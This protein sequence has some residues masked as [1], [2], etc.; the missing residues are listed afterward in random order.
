MPSA[1]LDHLSGARCIASFWIAC[2]HFLPSA[3]EWDTVS[4]ILLRSGVAVEFFITLSGFVTHWAYAEKAH[5]GTRGG[6]LQLYVRRF[7]R[8]AFTA[9]A[10]TFYMIGVNRAAGIVSTSP[11][12]FHAS[13]LCFVQPWLLPVL[14]S[15]A[16]FCP[17]GVVWTVACLLPSWLLYPFVHHRHLTAISFTRLLPLLLLALW[18]ALM[19]LIVTIWTAQGFYLSPSEATL[20][21]MW[22][23]ACLPAFAI[24]A[25]AAEA[26]RRHVRRRLPSRPDSHGTDESRPLTADAQSTTREATTTNHPLPVRGTS[27]YTRG[28]LADVAIIGP[29][30]IVC[31]LPAFH[32]DASG[33][34]A[35]PDVNSRDGYEPLLL[36]AF[37]PCF[38]AFLYATSTADTASG[39]RPGVIERL[40]RHPALV[41]LGDFSFVVF[42]FQAPVFRTF[43]IVYG[44]RRFLTLTHI[45][46]KLGVLALVVLYLSAGLYANFVEGRVVAWLRRVSDGWVSTADEE[47]ARTSGGTSRSESYGTAM[48]V[49]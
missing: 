22:P 29:I 19:V 10:T 37:A 2:R 34:V 14:S 48:A 21:Y 46:P 49:S 38:A 28:A 3:P 43:E 41:A 36:H 7:G 26:A 12:A 9:W 39:E 27:R 18:G 6:A 25:T 45:E 35:P 15:D 42:L 11:L 8:V 17:N 1:R 31:W 5:V 23:P 13:C 24:G 4:R 32:E 33:H 44:A 47:H 16:L 40:L 30:L 20:I